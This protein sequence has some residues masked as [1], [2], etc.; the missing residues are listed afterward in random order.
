MLPNA[1]PFRVQYNELMAHTLVITIDPA[2][3][4]AICAMP[5]ITN[6]YRVGENQ[7]HCTIDPKY[8][9]GEVL[10]HLMSYLEKLTAPSN[11]QEITESTP[12][13]GNATSDPQ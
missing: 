13:A 7:I 8:K 11:P 6:P 4:H 1:K 10:T 5:Y 2:Y 12:G 9:V 3:Y